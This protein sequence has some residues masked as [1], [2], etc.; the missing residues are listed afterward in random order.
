M[1]KYKDY[2]LKVKS[3]SSVKLHYTNIS[4]QFNTNFRPKTIDEAHKISADLKQASRVTF[5]PGNFLDPQKK[6]IF[7][8]LKED[9]SVK[10]NP[11]PDPSGSYKDIRKITVKAEPE[12]GTN[13]KRGGRMHLH[14]LI[15]IKH[16]KYIRID[17]M[18]IKEFYQQ[19]LQAISGGT[20]RPI[21]YTFWKTEKVTFKQYM[22]KYE[23]PSGDGFTV[24]EKEPSKPGDLKFTADEFQDSS[25][26]M[27]A[28]MAKAREE[29]GDKQPG[30]S[31][32][33]A[34]EYHNANRGVLGALSQVA[35]RDFILENF[36][37]KP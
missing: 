13:M 3:K 26:G 9:K 37:S 12:M 2:D 29:N 6:W 11:R 23:N 36:A 24:D 30:P 20:A 19:T 7:F 33:T 4:F 10:I 22:N 35:P 21:A 18:K 27:G 17:Y 28:A 25:E 5:D 15:K 32:F 31:K 16:I 8:I 14:G 1:F 34:E